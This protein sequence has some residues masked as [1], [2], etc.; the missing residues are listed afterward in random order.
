MAL[1]VPGVACTARHFFLWKLSL[2]SKS[3]YF[4]NLKLQKTPV[5]PDQSSVLSAILKQHF[6][7]QSY[8]KKCRRSNKIRYYY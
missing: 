1:G 7:K 3:I 5:D 8:L 2:V 4:E 6:W